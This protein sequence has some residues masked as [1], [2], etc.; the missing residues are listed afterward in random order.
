MNIEDLRKLAHLAQTQNLHTS[1]AAFNITTGA[2]SK[3]LKKI[4][5][6]LNNIIFDRVGRN[7]QINTNG[8]KFTLYANELI[9]QYDQMLSEFVSTQVK[10]SLN[11]AG[12][13]VLLDHVLDKLLP[14]ISTAQFE[15]NLEAVFEGDAINKL[16]SGAAHLAIVTDDALPDW[17]SAGFHALPLGVTTFELVAAKNHPIHQIETP[18]LAD[19]N[20][21]FFACPSSSAFCGIVRG[22]GSD[23]WPDH[24]YPRN[25]AFR[26]DNFA[27]LLNVIKKHPAL[28]YLP[29]IAIDEQLS[30]IKLSDFSAQNQ[31][32]INLVYKPSFST[33]WLN[34]LI[35]RI[36]ASHIHTLSFNE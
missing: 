27:S 32:R 23:G 18:A 6:Q 29:D 10:H 8:K 7:I 26:C 31:E 30:V 24:R 20:N 11:I 13:S 12:P 35:D 17:R 1:A 21:A 14:H 5:A 33:G 3:T 19:I 25:I 22:V 34:Q 15:V 9:H 4:E 36:S 16:K 2:L 28:A